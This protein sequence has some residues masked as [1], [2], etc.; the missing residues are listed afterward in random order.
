MKPL[1]LLLMVA[2]LALCACS[3]VSITNQWKDPAWPG[4][5]ASSVVVVG[6]SQSDLIRRKFE[7]SFS[8]QL[9][10]AGLK[11]VPSYTQIPPGNGGAVKLTDLV[12]SSGAEV[13]LV[14]RLLR[15]AQKIDVTPTGP[16]YGGF[17]GWYGGAWASTAQV[18]Q[19]D[20]VTLE[21]SIWDAKTQKLVWSVTTE[22][23]SQ[24]KI[25][26]ATAELAQALIPK[27][28]TDGILR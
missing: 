8:Q 6:I 16:G 10:A 28:R 27:L 2:S 15:V 19:Y 14:T 21:T 7:D 23:V 5:P 20:V 1:R 4:P 18:T 25:A 17:Y 3:T 22:A 13:V 12:R 9:Q 11:A 26:R 24:E